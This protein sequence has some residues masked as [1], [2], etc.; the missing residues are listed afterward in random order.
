[1]KESAHPGQQSKSKAGH[2]PGSTIIQHAGLGLERHTSKKTNY[3]C[4][5]LKKVEQRLRRWWTTLSQLQVAARNGMKTTYKPYAHHAT[6]E[7]PLKKAV[8]DIADSWVEGLNTHYRIYK[9]PMQAIRLNTIIYTLHL[10]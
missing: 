8:D 7:N 1:M 10:N 9:I 4:T 6:I 2:Q 3:V 5:V